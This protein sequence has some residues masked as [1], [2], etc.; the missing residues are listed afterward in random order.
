MGGHGRLRRAIIVAA[1]AAG[2]SGCGTVGGGSS[3]G[4]NSQTGGSSPPSGN[5]TVTTFIQDAPTPPAGSSTTSSSSF[6]D[7]P[8][9]EV[10]VSGA[11]L[12]GTGSNA[13]LT[14]SVQSVE[15]R[16]LDL[17]PTF[18]SVAQVTQGNTYTGLSLTLANPR[19]TVLNAQGQPVQLNGQTTPS[20]Q[21]AQSGLNIPLSI[22]VPTSGQIG[23]EVLFDMQRSISIDS[24][25]NYVITPV[26]NV[27]VVPNPPVNNQLEDTLG[28]I[29]SLSSSPQQTINVQLAGTN[30]TVIVLVNSNTQWEPAVGQFSNLQAGQNI[31]LDAQFQQD[32]TYLATFIGSAPTNLSMSFRGVL[33]AIS[34]DASGNTTISLV[35]QN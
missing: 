7:A 1:L 35:A 29:R 2:L 4:T 32:G 23:L 13:S 24:N 16:H 18:E 26:V 21:L 22:S 34:Q 25:G 9:F 17:A 12:T 11:T 3:S 14:N 10:D 5:G 33:T 30:Q 15:L 31:T 19:L 6:S 27:S 8:S 28:T 20:V